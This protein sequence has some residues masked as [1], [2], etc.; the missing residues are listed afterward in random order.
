M[1]G[2]G[3]LREGI[4]MC[5]RFEWSGLDGAVPEISSRPQNARMWLLVGVLREFVIACK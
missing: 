1:V 5:A 4:K 3:W 2:I